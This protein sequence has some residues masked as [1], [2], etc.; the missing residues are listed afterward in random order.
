MHNRMG[1][2]DTLYI[3]KNPYMEQEFADGGGNREEAHIIA[4]KKY[5]YKKEVWDARNKKPKK[6]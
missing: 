2:F 4:S 1:E 5:N 3:R 6:D